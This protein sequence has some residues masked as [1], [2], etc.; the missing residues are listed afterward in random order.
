MIHPRKKAN[1]MFFIALDGGNSIQAYIA[2]YIKR[3][4]EIGQ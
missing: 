2:K 4:A 3:G 1:G